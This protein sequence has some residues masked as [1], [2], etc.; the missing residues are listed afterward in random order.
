MALIWTDFGRRL[1]PVC[2]LNERDL[3]PEK[4]SE[5]DE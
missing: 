1:N 2:G 3:D 5:R 4:E